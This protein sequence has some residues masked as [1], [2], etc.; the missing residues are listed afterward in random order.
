MGT[1]FLNDAHIAAKALWDGEEPMILKAWN[2]GDGA[3]FMERMI[4]KEEFL[5]E[6]RQR[7]NRA[8]DNIAIFNLPITLH[9]GPE[10]QAPRPTRL[11]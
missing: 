4:W 11:Q 6:K 8:A 5:A 3:S 10:D 1:S 9:P 2:L 7:R